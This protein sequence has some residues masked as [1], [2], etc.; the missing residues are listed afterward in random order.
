MIALDTNILVR[1]ITRDD[2]D[3]ARGVDAL[4]SIPEETFFL[5]DIV[6]AEL[7]W[8][9]SRSYGFSKPEVAEV[10]IALMDRLDVVFEDEARVRAAVRLYVEG[11]DLADGLILETARAAGCTSMA[12][13]DESLIHRAP[14]FVR[15]P[16]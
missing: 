11:L 13:F 12:S 7:T 14:A 10:L 4:L 16:K 3:Q 8:V 2:P 9:L 1:F 6:L 15:R 5:P